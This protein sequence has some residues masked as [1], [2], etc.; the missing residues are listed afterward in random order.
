MGT[1]CHVIVEGGPNRCPELL[2]EAVADLE[3]RWT[4][5]SSDSEVSLLN[6]AGVAGIRVTRETFQL[7]RCGL[8]GM[9][10]SGGLFDPFLAREI[11]AAGYDRDFAEL[12]AITGGPEECE[13]IPARAR[14]RE[15]RARVEIDA[16]TGW[17]RLPIGWELDSGGL[18]KGLAADMVSELG[19]RL[20]A[21]ACLV[22]LG[23]DLRVRGVPESGRWQIEVADESGKGGRGVTVNLTAGALCTSSTARRR[24]RTSDGGIT[25]HLLDPRTGAAARRP[26]VAATAIAPHGWLAEVLSKFVLLADRRRAAGVLRRHRA[27]AVLRRSDGG[28]EQWP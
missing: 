22:N 3:R 27:G 1:S 16:R 7:V 2:V 25:H 13:P 5:F 10:L 28:V 17:V 21:R 24:W 12:P 26:W 20:G 11:G 8:V 4:R 14:R 18:G 6:R 23:G 19:I 9:R 15:R